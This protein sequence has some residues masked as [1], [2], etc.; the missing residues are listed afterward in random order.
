MVTEHVRLSDYDAVSKGDAIP[1][2]AE[3]VLVFDGQLGERAGLHVAIAG[4]SVLAGI[5]LAVTSFFRLRAARPWYERR[6]VVDT[7]NGP[8]VRV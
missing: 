1:V 7:G 5:V 6:K 2:L 8:I 4:L 3:R